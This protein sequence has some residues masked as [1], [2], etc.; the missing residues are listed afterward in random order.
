[1]ASIKKKGFRLTFIEIFFRFRVDE[2]VADPI[3]GKKGNC[4]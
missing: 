1:M 4:Q 3:K 2:G